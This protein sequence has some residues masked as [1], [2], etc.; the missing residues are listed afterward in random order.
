[1]TVYY[2]NE[3]AQLGDTPPRL[4]GNEGVG[5][6][7]RWYR[8]T[9]SLNAPKTSST[10]NGSWI[11]TTDTVVL[12]TR[13]PGMRFARGFITSSVS[14]GT[15]T[16]SIGVPGNPGR[17]RAPATFVVSDT[18]LPFGIASQMAA[19]ATATS[20]D[21]ILTIATATLPTPVGGVLIIDMEF[22]GP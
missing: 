21:V 9:I 10:T 16:I 18:P 20:E 7:S 2:A 19:A 13:P 22:M 4:P 6:R 17:Y 3:Q 8:A 1:M 5:G 11:G 14:L 12:F 15:A